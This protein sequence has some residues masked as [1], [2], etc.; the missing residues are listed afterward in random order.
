MSGRSV[1]YITSG[2]IDANSLGFQSVTEAAL[3]A[4]DGY[5]ASNQ[6]LDEVQKPGRVDTILRAPRQLGIDLPCKCFGS[7]EW[8]MNEWVEVQSCLR[9]HERKL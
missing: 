8:E 9:G 4:H 6:S 2:G 5:L 1:E 7:E 3:A